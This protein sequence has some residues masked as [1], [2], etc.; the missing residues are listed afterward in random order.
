MNTKK[1]FIC[2]ICL[3]LFLFPGNFISITLL[4]TYFWS[5]LMTCPY[6]LSLPSLIFILNRSTLTIPLMCS[7]LIF[8]F[9]IT[10]YQTST[11]S[12]LQPPFLLFVSLS[13]PPFQ[14]HT[15]LLVSPRNCTLFL[16]LLLVTSYHKLLLILFSIRSILPTLFFLRPSHNYHFLHR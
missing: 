16:L 1:F 3:P 14:V 10:P 6:H 13:P 5:L 7:F 8:Y 9:L 2:K 11:F 15:P 4:P 12:S